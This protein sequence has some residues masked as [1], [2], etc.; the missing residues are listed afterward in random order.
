MGSLQ[1]SRAPLSML[2]VE[3]DKL[4]LDILARVIARK[5]PAATINVAENGKIG[6]EFFKEHVPDIVITDINMPEMDG[7]QMARE[8]K[9][10]KADTKFIVLTAYSNKSYLMQ[11]REIGC[12]AYLM[13]PIDFGKLCDAIE[14]CII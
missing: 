1:N 4:T 14:N 9:A 6:L 12:C 2:I 13:K 7:I 3:D 11:F 10:I 8:I 5:F